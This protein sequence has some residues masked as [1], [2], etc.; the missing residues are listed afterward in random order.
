MDIRGL[1][2]QRLQLMVDSGLVS[3]FADIFELTAPRIAQ[4]E[5]LGDKSAEALVA[6][7][8]EAKSRPLERLVNAL[9]IHHVGSQTARLLARH[10]GSLDSLMRAS[11]DDL[12]AVHGIGEKTAV[13]VHRFLASRPVREL[14][15]RLKR[16]G[17][18]T[19]E[20][21]TGATSG[22]LRGKVVVITGTLPTLSREQATELVESAGGKVTG[23]V[24]K[25]TDFVVAGENPGS[26][27]EKA[28]DFGIEVVDEAELRRRVNG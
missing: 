4:L 3:D 2:Y 15:Q 25:R 6:A 26:K 27:L 18:N 14:V 22:I 8:S 24:S 1:S 20:S 7:I 12:A 11:V 28:R 19:I 17:V 10:F 9:G 5:R 21:Q 13:E 23:S 16:L